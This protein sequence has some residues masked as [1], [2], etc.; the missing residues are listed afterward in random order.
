MIVLLRKN[1][2]RGSLLNYI[3]KLVVR[4]SL[5]SQRTTKGA[6]NTGSIMFC[7][8]H[9]HKTASSR[10]CTKENDKKKYERHSVECGKR[11]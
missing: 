3:D 10:R 8:S 1:Y 4:S 11:T 7:C 6:E 5:I 9:I 2:R